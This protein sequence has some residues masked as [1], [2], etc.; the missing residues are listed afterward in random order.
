[1]T[2]FCVVDE[3][4]TQTISQHGYSIYLYRNTPNT[5]LV[6]SN[7]VYI[8]N[9]YDKSFRI[10]KEDKKEPIIWGTLQAIASEEGHTYLFDSR[11]I[12]VMDH[13]TLQLTSLFTSSK[14]TIINSVA[15]DKKGTFWMGTSRGLECYSVQTNELSSVQTNLFTDVSLVVCHNPD[16][17]WI[18]AENMLFSYSPHKER[19]TIYGESDGV[20][21]NE[22]IPRSQLIIDEQGIYMGG[23]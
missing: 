19:F 18:G 2:P 11:R 16:E 23:A 1:M 7:H 9:L 12:Y 4:T 17:I 6:L 8:Y 10:A 15:Y 5:V 22:Y 20:M 14:E 3:T 13:S 21:P